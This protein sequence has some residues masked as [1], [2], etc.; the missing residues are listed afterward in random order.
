MEPDIVERL[1]EAGL[2]NGGQFRARHDAVMTGSSCGLT[3]GA[4]TSSDY[5]NGVRAALWLLMGS[6]RHGGSLHAHPFHPSQESSLT[7]DP[8]RGE[9]G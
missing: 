8:S 3:V 4:S 6:V 7:L 2:T 1:T 9:E 5:R